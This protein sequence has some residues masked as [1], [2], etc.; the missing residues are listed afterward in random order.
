VSFHWSE[1]LRTGLPEIDAQH[2]AL[3]SR[4]NE[5]IAA[6]LHRTGKDEIGRVLAFLSGYVNRHFDDEERVM[7]ACSYTGLQQHQE[8]HARFRQRLQVLADTYREQGATD[9]VVA[10]TVWAAAEWFVEHIRQVDLAMASVV[11]QWQERNA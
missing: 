11:R 1:D 4:F 8:E 6:C 3:I 7:A 5:M 9:Q 10:D 2:Q